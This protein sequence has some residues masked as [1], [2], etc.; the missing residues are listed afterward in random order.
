MTVERVRHLAAV[1]FADIV[2]YTEFSSRDENAALAVV[3]ELQR[4]ARE[5]VERVRGRIVKFQGDA[6]LAVFDSTDAALRAAL[7]LQKSF[8]AS[9]LVERH[10]C[11]LT[12]GVHVG[13]VVE[14][15]DGDIY[16]DGVNLAS[17]IEGV[18]KAGQVVVS[19]AIYAQIS[20][21]LDYET[22]A[23]GTR[24]LKGVPS[25]T[26]VFLVGR[27]GD[28][29][30]VKPWSRWPLPRRRALVALGIAVGLATLVGL[31]VVLAPWV[32]T[33]RS[34]TTV[35]GGLVVLPFEGPGEEVETARL[36]DLMQNALGFLPNLQVIDG[37]DL[38]EAGAG[39]WRSH[40]MPELLQGAAEK[41]G[42]YLLVGVVVD[43]GEGL[44]LAVDGYSVQS[45]ERLFRLEES[46]AS[47]RIEDA[48]D[49]LAL[50]VAREL[51][52]TGVDV[53]VPPYLLRSTAS[54]RA[55]GHLLQ[56]QDDFYRADW[57]GAKTSFDRAIQADSSFALAYH[58]RSIV[59]LWGWDYPAA[60]SSA[61]LGIFQ[62]AS[63]TREW[64]DLLRAQRLL[65]TGQ[66]DSVLDLMERYVSDFPENAD[67]WFLLGEAR[68]RFS[69]VTGG[70]AADAI[71]GWERSMR[72]NNNLTPVREI[73]QLALESG[74]E[75]LARAHLE[76]I[77]EADRFP[78]AAFDLR[79]GD[80]SVRE[81]TLR[82]L[83][84]SERRV[85][86]ELVLYLGH[87]EL[88]L[89]LADTLAS[90]LLEPQ[91]SNAD[92]QRGAYYRLAL[93]AALGRLDEALATWSLLRSG[94]AFDLVIVDAYLAGYPVDRYAFP[95]FADAL[96]LARAG[97][98]PN[99]AEDDPWDESR[100]SFRALVHRAVMEG[101]SAQV[102]FLLARLEA[103]LS[104]ADASDPMPSNLRAALRGRMALLA[105]DTSRAIGWL[106]ES[107]TH[108]LTHL[109]VYPLMSMAAERLLLAEIHAARGEYQQAA[110]WVRTFGSA[111]ALT[112]AL[113]HRRLSRIKEDI[114]YA[115][116]PLGTC[117][118]A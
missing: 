70:C 109:K 18:A 107:V 90:M 72:I 17:R 20:Q 46:P 36:H 60:L 82:E 16:G 39:G 54:A 78:R 100:R 94:D 71:P 92:Q 87:D 93:S 5:E 115:G 81:A 105:S 113:Y 6:V 102:V 21:R 9:D 30:D 65:V 52:A 45:G 11:A 49:R 47:A 34:T 4:I 37:A 56:G 43:G 3:D 98:A 86:S 19:E 50:S 112:D 57:D 44:T 41:G 29:A 74:N 91:R 101:D 110:L 59:E 26:K 103:T 66:A 95:M 96:E 12:I 42:A 64:R 2:G 118:G 83:R 63:A 35:V 117:G 32:A 14:A 114:A 76:E 80:A 27:A 1:W 33:S 31:A 106:R 104:A 7:S 38:L 75:E 85:I 62:T 58:R 51:S 40:G 84:G 10:R 15:E 108:P 69:A 73:V 116:V 97:G 68:E 99:Y 24:R 53:G 89:P 67:G 22:R 25:P 13:E 8:S 88:D 55:L 48:A 111:A 23:L 28:L 79:F 61:D 77:P